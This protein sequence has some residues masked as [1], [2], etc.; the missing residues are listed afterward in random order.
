MDKIIGRSASEV[1][2]DGGEEGT[3]LVS[4][5]P[6]VNLQDWL[7]EADLASIQMATLL[8]KRLLHHYHDRLDLNSYF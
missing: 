2:E 8:F 3:R 7:C 5:L 1:V 4:V 6:R